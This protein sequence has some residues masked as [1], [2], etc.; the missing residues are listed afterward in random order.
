MVVS[1]LYTPNV[2]EQMSTHDMSGR[3]IGKPHI[4]RRPLLLSGASLLINPKEAGWPPPQHEESWPGELPTVKRNDAATTCAHVMTCG[5]RQPRE[6]PLSK[7]I[8][9]TAQRQQLTSSRAKNRTEQVSTYSRTGII[10][11]WTGGSFSSELTLKLGKLTL[12][13]GGG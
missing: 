3:H 7:I 11:R 10:S 8:G 12:D 9:G 4:R 6:T 1:I 13:G 5:H 2:Q